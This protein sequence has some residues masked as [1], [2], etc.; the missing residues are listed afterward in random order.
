[1]QASTPYHRPLSDERRNAS[2][3]EIAQLTVMLRAWAATGTCTLL[4]CAMAPASS[5]WH[6]PRIAAALSWPG[7]KPIADRSYGAP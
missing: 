2:A 3:V 4:L 5:V 6:S 7:W 1:M